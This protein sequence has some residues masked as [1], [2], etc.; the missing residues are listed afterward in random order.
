MPPQIPSIKPNRY[1]SCGAAILRTRF[2]PRN[3]RPSLVA[4]VTAQVTTRSHR[5]ENGCFKN[6]EEQLTSGALLHF[7]NAARSLIERRDEVLR[8][9]GAFP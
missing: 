2:E 3:R 7:P 1:N 6:I 8:L 9:I 5:Q 4:V